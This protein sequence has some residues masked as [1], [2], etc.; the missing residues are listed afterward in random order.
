MGRTNIFA[1]GGLKNQ[2][3]PTSGGRNPMEIPDPFSHPLGLSLHP[4]DHDDERTF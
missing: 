3:H 4:D 1:G 2:M